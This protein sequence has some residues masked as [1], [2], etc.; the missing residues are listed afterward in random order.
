MYFELVI[1]TPCYHH[2]QHHQKNVYDIND[3]YDT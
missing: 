3:I 2:H 1:Q